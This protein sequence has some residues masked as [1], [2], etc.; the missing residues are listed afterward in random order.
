M[1]A[2]KKAIVRPQLEFINKTSRYR[3][4]NLRRNYRV[5]RYCMGVCKVFTQADQDFPN[6]TEFRKDKTTIF[7]AVISSSWPNSKVRPAYKALELECFS[8]SIKVCHPLFRCEAEIHAKL[9]NPIKAQFVIS[10]AQ[11]APIR[12]HLHT[13]NAAFTLTLFAV[14]A[15]E[16]IK[17]L[18]LKDF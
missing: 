18:I 15:L 8:R 13:R 2:L 12:K 1:S 10:V 6:S 16:L 7:Q 14:F 9:K 4:D 3:V 11:K 17:I 5:G